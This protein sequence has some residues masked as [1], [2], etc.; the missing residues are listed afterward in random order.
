[1]ALKLP[2]RECGHVIPTMQQD[3]A[4]AFDAVIGAKA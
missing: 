1:L 4:A 2:L 3:A